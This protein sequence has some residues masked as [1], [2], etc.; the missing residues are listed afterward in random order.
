[1]ATLILPARI[2]RNGFNPNARIPYRVTTAHIRAAMQ[3]FIEFLSTI[4]GQLHAKRMDRFENIIMQA[5]FS[6][7]VGELISASIPKQ[8]KTV[9]KNCYHNGHP[10]LLPSR[11]YANNSAQ[12]AGRNGIEIKASRYMKA[13]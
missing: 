2:E 6:S 4:D 12:H 1:M 10:D 5:N 13:W 9:V 11:R 8:C 7:I 3:D